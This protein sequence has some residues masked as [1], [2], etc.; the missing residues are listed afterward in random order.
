MYPNPAVR[1]DTLTC[2]LSEPSRSTTQTF[3]FLLPFSSEAETCRYSSNGKLSLRPRRVFP[4]DRI[5]HDIVVGFFYFF[6]TLESE[7][8]QHR[9]ANWIAD[10]VQK[11]IV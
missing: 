4:T 8:R 11:C 3:F 5:H 6:F 9:M 10:S 2:R 1:P 7:T